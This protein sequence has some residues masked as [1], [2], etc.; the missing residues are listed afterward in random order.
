MLLKSFYPNLP[1]VE[2]TR[3]TVLGPRVSEKSS[4]SKNSLHN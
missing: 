4:F 2:D 1:H 3:E